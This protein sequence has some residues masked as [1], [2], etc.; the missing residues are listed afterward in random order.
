MNVSRVPLPDFRRSSRTMTI[1]PFFASVLALALLPNPISTPSF[2]SAV[3][4]SGSRADL[5]RA[6]L[7]ATSWV[8]F[9][10]VMMAVARK[11]R[12]VSA[13]GM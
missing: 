6:R 5:S 4:N 9:W 12:V 1:S 3:P 2:P 10:G 7:R 8:K 13:V 11:R